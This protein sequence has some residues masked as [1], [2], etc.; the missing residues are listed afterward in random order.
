MRDVADH[1]MA[2]SMTYDPELPVCFHDL[3]FAARDLERDHAF[4]WLARLRQR[5]AQ[6]SEIQAQI[7]E[8]LIQHGSGVFHAAE[9]VG[10]AKRLFRAWLS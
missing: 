5:K 1:G 8:Y 2:L 10:T 7:E 9:Q 4:E 6:W 3:I